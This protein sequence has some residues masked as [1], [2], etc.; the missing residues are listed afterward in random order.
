MTPT[1]HVWN[2]SSLDGMMCLF[3]VSNTHTND[4]KRNFTE[5]DIKTIIAWYYIMRDMGLITLP[6]KVK[7]LVDTKSIS[8]LLNIGSTNTSMF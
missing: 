6:Q 5:T 3:E 7:S 2:A 8:E 1:F 4:L